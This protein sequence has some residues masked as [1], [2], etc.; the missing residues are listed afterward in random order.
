[1]KKYIKYFFYRFGFSRIW[2]LCIFRIAQIRYRKRNLSY[3]KKHPEI[4]L[5]DDY[6]LHETFQLDYQ[7]YI[8]EGKL[9]AS[10]IQA[11]TA[12]LF[13]KLTPDNLLDWGCGTGRITRHLQ[14][15]FPQ[16]NIFGCDTHTQRMEWNRNHSSGITFT[17]IHPFPPTP[18]ANDFFD[19][20]IGFSVLTHIEVDDQEAWM[21]ELYRILK[22]GGILWFTTQGNNYDHQLMGFEKRKLQK[23]GMYTRSGNRSGHRIMTTYHL[24]AGFQEKISKYFSIRQ[25]FSGKTNSSKTGGQD[26]WLV[27]K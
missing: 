7:K 23:Q 4:L 27:Q 24:A 1:M 26:I 5:P 9:A 2:D 22:P 14:E 15:V 13:T 19:L 18:Y 17:L 21:A 6:D 10:E 16:A 3:V 25:F 12:H 20:I 8:E 11:D